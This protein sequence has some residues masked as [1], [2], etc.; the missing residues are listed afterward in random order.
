MQPQHSNHVGSTGFDRRSDR[1]AFLV[2]VAAI[3]LGTL[4]GTAAPSGLALA[5]PRTRYQDDPIAVMARHA[6][7]ARTSGSPA[8]EQH[9][10]DQRD[11]AADLAAQRLGL[12]PVAMRQAWARADLPHQIALLTGLTQLGVPYRRNRSEAGIG[13]DCSGLTTY[14]WAG[15][16][17]ELTRQSSAQIREAAPRT[18]D[19]AQAGDLMQYPGHI[20]IWLGTD[21]AVLQ[22]PY[23]GSTVEIVHYREGRGV[24]VGDPNG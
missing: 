8:S 7:L 5:A 13:F 12:A 19:T 6:L 16:G 20:M 14:A 10:R 4:A 24:N 21:R 3:G 22:S 18:I 11:L 17:V 1:R 23:P 2:G 15:A 9:Y